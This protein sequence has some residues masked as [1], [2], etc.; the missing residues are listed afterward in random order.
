L[1]ELVVTGYATQKKKDLT[2]SI[3]V[4]NV[5]ELK[6]QP[7]AS[8][9]AAL[10]GKAS[11]VQVINDGAPGATPQIRI[12]G[13]STINNNDPLYIIDGVPYEGKLSWLN[14]SD[15]ASMQVLKD[16]SAASI[17]GSRANNGVVIITTK[18][19]KKGPPQV[20][21]SMYYGTQRPN[22]NRFPEFLTP[23]KYAEYV[24]ERYKN[25][26]KTPGTNATTGTNYGTDP[27]KPVL[28]DYLLAGNKTGHEITP[29]D[30]D[31]SKYNYTMDPA[32]FY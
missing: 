13:F 22:R 2:G 1:D 16:A 5:D 30:A 26:E 9:I 19:G 27:D 25:A 24:Y 3:D 4:V 7:A 14:S 15:I 12:R 32:L 31:P 8:P 23:M 10:Q 20:S 21:L 17:Y 29:A 18:K 28:P 6:K 11:G